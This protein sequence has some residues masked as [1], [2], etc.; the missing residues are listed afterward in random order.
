[1]LN[2]RNQNF[3]KKIDFYIG[4]FLLLILRLFKKSPPS[5]TIIKKKNLIFGVFAFA[6]IGD[7]ILSSL[8]FSAIKKNNPNAT[9]IIFAS[10]S[11]IAVYS[12]LNK[13]D[14]VV[15]L[16]I[17]K[18][19]KSIQ[20]IRNYN[21]DILI[22][23]SQWARISAL[24]SFFSKAKLTIGFKTKGQFRHFNYDK[25]V[26]HSYDV[27]EIKNFKNLLSPLNYFS[28]STIP[29]KK[30]LLFEKNKF[31]TKDK[32][33]IIHPWASGF[34]SNMREWPNYYWSELCVYLI[35]LNYKVVITGSREDKKNSILIANLVNDSKNFLVLAGKLSLQ[36][37][38]RLINDAN[39]I[40]CVNTGVMHIA[41]LLKTP[42]ISLHG[43]TNP[44]R[45]GPINKKLGVINVSLNDGGAYLNLGFEYPKNEN[46]L[47][48]KISVDA[49]VK[50]L[51]YILALK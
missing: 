12:L 50:R 34:K 43:P 15:L 20:I 6:A 23:T 36:D 17:T 40:I 18:P 42:M 38:V 10:Q 31:I 16:P 46:Y 9:I 49:V 24:Y 48:S 26:T 4:V 28:R 33:I 21:I 19:I 14:S 30:D 29:F 47:M 3:L 44:E 7:S 27:H 22:D 5:N 1:M 2:E 45:W 8:I 37:L 11:N 32:F 41:S 39:C 25:F 51:K 13:F 35:S